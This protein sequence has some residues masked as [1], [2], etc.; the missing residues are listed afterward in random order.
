MQAE[1]TRSMPE[2]LCGRSESNREHSVTDSYTYDP[3]SWN[4]ILAGV[5]AGAMAAIVAALLALLLDSPNRTA[6]NSLVVVLLALA[7]GGASG[8]LWRRVRAS[9]NAL[10]IFGWTI[11]GGFI[12]TLAGIT[13]ADQSSVDNLIGYAVPLAAV[14]FI[15]VGF[16]TPLLDGVTA[17]QWAAII[18]VIIAL[19]L[20][21]AFLGIDTTPSSEVSL[22]FSAM[23]HATGGF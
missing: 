15:T 11:A 7:I 16:I 2:P 4:P 3:D 8:L 13:I 21:V 20:G 14:I 22:Q 17:P 6:G 23:L 19:L 12:I 9:Q 18:P 10:R 5:V 1:R